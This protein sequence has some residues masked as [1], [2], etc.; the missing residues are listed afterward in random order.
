MSGVGVEVGIIVGDAAFTLKTTVA[1][2][3]IDGA[4]VVV[5][6][7]VCDGAGACVAQPS[8]MMP[9]ASNTITKARVCM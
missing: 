4:G 1:S 2:I 3:L 9:A 6:T 8:P 5:G 7:G